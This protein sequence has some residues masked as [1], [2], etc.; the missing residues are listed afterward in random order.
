M[1]VR[2]HSTFGSRSPAEFDAM[3]SGSSL[4]VHEI[5]EAQSSRTP[6]THR[7][8]EGWPTLTNRPASWAYLMLARLLTV[9]SAIAERVN[10]IE[11]PGCMKLLS[12]D[13]EWWWWWSPVWVD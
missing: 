8:K 7:E 13:R 4:G 12:K 3:A 9:T 11:T 10:D 5:G 1:R 6:V 2:R